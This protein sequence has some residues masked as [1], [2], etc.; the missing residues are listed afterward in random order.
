LPALGALRERW[1]G[2]QLEVLG[3]PH[4]A[5]LAHGRRYADALRPITARAMAGFFVPNGSL[6]PEWMDYFGSFN[7]VISYLFDPDE[8][9]ADNVRRCGVKQFIA[10]A[11]Q[12]RDLPAAE[13][14]CR[15]LETLAIYVEQPVPRVYPSETDREFAVRFFS[16]HCGAVGPPRPTTEPVGQAGPS[17]PFAVLH[18]GSGSAKKNWPVEKFAALARWLVDELALPLVV[19]RGEADE[20]VVGNLSAALVPRPV[21][22]ATGLKLVELAGV[23]E[24][25]AVFAGNDSGI[26]HLAAAVG[27]PTVALFG[28]A[29]VPIW[30]PR[31]DRVRVVQFGDADTLR[32]RQ[33]IG[34]L[35]GAL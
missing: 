5:E 4:I 18:P 26:T 1:P 9:F 24:R 14:Y 27:A 8:V 35:L 6:D 20:R 29:S 32:V 10:A 11:P 13:H 19:V 16:T 21:T 3:Y 31:G 17:P 25:C 22:L 33:A 30:E 12:P 34:E 23:L 7:V 28:P 15:P 2:A